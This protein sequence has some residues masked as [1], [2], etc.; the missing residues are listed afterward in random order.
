MKGERIQYNKVATL[1]AGAIRIRTYADSHGITV[2]YVYKLYKAG[3]I[4]IVD[5]EGINFVLVA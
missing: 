2:A 1:P 5:Y 4:L 3:K